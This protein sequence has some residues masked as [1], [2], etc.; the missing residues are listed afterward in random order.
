MKLQILITL[1][2]GILA[3]P[4]F[5]ATFSNVFSS[6]HGDI[7]IALEDDGEFFFH[8]GLS[9]IAVVNGTPLGGD[10]AELEPSEVVT[11][12]PSSTLQTQN[13]SNLNAATGITA[14]SIWV[15]PELSTTA[16][17][18]TAP[19]LGFGTE[20]LNPADWVGDISFSLVSVVSPSGSGTFTG[21]TAASDPFASPGAVDIFFSSLLPGSTLG[22]NTLG[23]QAGGETH[24]NLG[25]SEPGHW[26]VEFTVEGTNV[27]PTLGSGGTLSS[28][29]TFNF[30]VVPEP[31]SALLVVFGGLALMSRRRA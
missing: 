24:L 12:V 17:A 1:V 28:T 3:N 10:G 18:L 9:D 14:G 19:F 16:T 6:G 15:L 21:W 29:R 4:V 7:G 5:S 13:N 11:V 22:A 30:T 8:V 23:V 31:S 25:F 27:D 2:I 20:E 26:E